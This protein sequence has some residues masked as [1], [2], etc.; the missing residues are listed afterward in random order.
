MACKFA[1]SL[2]F[3]GFYSKSKLQMKPWITLL[4][5]L[6]LAVIQNFM[7]HLSRD[8]AVVIH[9]PTRRSI[10]SQNLSGSWTSFFLHQKHLS[11]ASIF[12]L[13]KFSLTKHLLST[14]S[15]RDRVK[16]QL[17]KSYLS[18]FQNKTARLR[19]LKKPDNLSKV[20]SSCQEAVNM[21]TSHHGQHHAQ[22]GKNNKGKKPSPP[23]TYTCIFKEL[24]LANL[25]HCHKT[26]TSCNAACAY[27]RVRVLVSFLDLMW[28][29]ANYRQS[30][31]CSSR[32]IT[33]L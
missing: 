26:V 32:C 14:I 29:I 25:K 31:E 2:K 19:L 4:Y 18:P 6:A 8:L 17:L 11:R 15:F 30:R 9:N 1:E 3:L 16:I 13:P 33:V 28:P 20:L 21:S 22:K 10:Y 24:G 12:N 5:V 23:P 27:C 7:I